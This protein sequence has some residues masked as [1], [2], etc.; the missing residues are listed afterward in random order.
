MHPYLLRPGRGA[1]TLRI[2]PRISGRVLA[3]DGPVHPRQA[4]PDQHLAL[5]LGR[6]RLMRS[7]DQR[8]LE[9]LVPAMTLY[10]RVSCDVLAPRWPP[11][12]R[13]L[14]SCRRPV[15]VALTTLCGLC[16][17]RHLV[18]MFWM[19]AAS[20][21]A[22]TA[23]PAMT[24]VPS[25]GRP[26]ATPGPRRSRPMTSW[27]MVRVST[28]GTLT[29]PSWPARCP[30]G[31]PRAPRWPCPGRMPTEPLPSPTTTRR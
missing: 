7:S 11:C 9:L 15:M 16:E 29:G 12:P 1:C 14:R 31:S 30:C 23:P 3:H 19:P 26:A 20:T 28:S 2:M 22:R 27:G 10:L 17:P 13:R 5:L 18:R 4:E 6:G 24:P 25:R 21:T 8:D